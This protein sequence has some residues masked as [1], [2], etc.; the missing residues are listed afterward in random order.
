MFKRARWF[1]VGAAAGAGA[2]MYSFV[3]LRESRDRFSPENVADT[4]VGTAR[5]AGHT[6]RRATVVLGSS[7]RDA[8]GEGRVA[9]LEAEERIIADLDRRQP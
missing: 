9:M 8:V 5:A 1:T 7:V 6:A 3:R 4:V 2:V